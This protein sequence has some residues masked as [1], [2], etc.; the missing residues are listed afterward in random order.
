MPHTRLAEAIRARGFRRWY[1]RQLYES[2]AHLLTGLL[3]LIAMGLALE[4]IEFRQSASQ[5]LLLVAIGVG[6]SCLC[7]FAWRK[8]TFQLFRAEYL[9]ERA[10]CVACS[11]YG[12]LQVVAASPS[13]DSLTGCALQVRC[14]QCSH[15]WT[16]E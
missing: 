8:F 10:T 7:V 3:S 5:F 1:E 14:R 4:M 2:H 13:P 16:I 15:E 6:A 11:C 9:A 12:R